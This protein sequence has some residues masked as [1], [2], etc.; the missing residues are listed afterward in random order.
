M[1]RGEG[2][3]SA[4]TMVERRRLKVSSQPVKRVGRLVRKEPPQEE[5]DGWWC[6]QLI[7]RK[8]P[9]KKQK[10]GPDWL[11]LRR[12]A[13]EYELGDAICR[14]YA[15]LL[16]SHLVSI[17]PDPEDA[18]EYWRESCNWHRVKHL[19]DIKYEWRSETAN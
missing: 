2:K 13:E 8:K 6:P 4:S 5:D 19:Y 18:K 1:L 12:L 3:R 7:E 17:D 16:A 14:L 10:R 11:F 9:R 15:G